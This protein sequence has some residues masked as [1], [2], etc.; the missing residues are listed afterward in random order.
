[1]HHPSWKQTTWQAHVYSKRKTQ[2]NFI[3]FTMVSERVHV[4]VLWMVN[5]LINN[6]ANASTKI[7]PKNTIVFAPFLHWIS[8]Q[9]NLKFSI[10]CRRLP[11][12]SALVCLA[13]ECALSSGGSYNVKLSHFIVI[14][15]KHIGNAH[16]RVLRSHQWCN[17]LWLCIHNGVHRRCLYT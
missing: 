2:H 10:C 15:W 6:N 3:F 1:M 13:F 17:V 14:L 16:I 7:M 5:K 8:R 11:F 9:I 4:R 12:R